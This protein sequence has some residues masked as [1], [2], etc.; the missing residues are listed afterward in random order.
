[1]PPNGRVAPNWFHGDTLDVRRHDRDRREP[2]RSA[3]PLDRVWFPR[4][5]GTDSTAKRRVDFLIPSH[6]GIHRAQPL[7]RAIPASAGPSVLPSGIPGQ[8]RTNQLEIE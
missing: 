6:I 4:P 8:S 3:P 7:T 5:D 2:R 1:V